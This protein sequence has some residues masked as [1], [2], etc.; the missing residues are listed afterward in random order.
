MEQYAVERRDFESWQWCIVPDTK[1]GRYIIAR[2]D[3]ERTAK[4]FCNLL[5]IDAL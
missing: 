3:D 1:Y 5:N 2:F 4:R